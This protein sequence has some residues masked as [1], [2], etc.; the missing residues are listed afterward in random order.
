MEDIL[1]NLLTDSVTEKVT[2]V[3]VDSAVETS[4]DGVLWEL[5]DLLLETPGLAEGAAGILGVPVLG[6]VGIKM[7]R[8]WRKRTKDGN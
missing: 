8:K 6:I 3:V 7:L 4:A 5:A 2:E 1:T